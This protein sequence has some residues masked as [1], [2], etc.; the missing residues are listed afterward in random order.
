MEDSVGELEKDEKGIQ[1]SPQC[2]VIVKWTLTCTGSRISA[3]VKEEPHQGSEWLPGSDSKTHLE[4]PP[5][6]EE[7]TLESSDMPVGDMGFGKLEV[8]KEPIEL[9]VNEESVN[10]EGMS[11]GS[12][13]KMTFDDFLMA[14]DVKVISKEEGLKWKSDGSV[15]SCRSHEKKVKLEPEKDPCGMLCVKSNLKEPEGY[16]GEELLGRERK[17]GEFNRDVV[18]DAT[19]LNW[20]RSDWMLEYDSCLEQRHQKTP[21]MKKRAVENHSLSHATVED[22]DFPVEPDWF[23]VGGEVVNGLS[24]TKGKKIVDNE[25]VHFKFSMNMSSKNNTRWILRF[26]T[27]R[28]GEVSSQFTFFALKNYLVLLML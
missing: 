17:T 25:I 2:P 22:G 14:T 16:V 7:A 26:S 24:T 28:H 20:A 12:V 3:R 19:P 6:K 18:I 11:V 10:N 9:R 5:V 1:S 23:L 21:S 4:I 15:E 8:E 27:K 13:R